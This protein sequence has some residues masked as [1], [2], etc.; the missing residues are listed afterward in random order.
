MGEGCTWGKVNIAR[1]VQRKLP[2]LE[3]HSTEITGRGIERF[4][5]LKRFVEKKITRGTVFGM[6]DQYREHFQTFLIVVVHGIL[7]SGERVSLSNSSKC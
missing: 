4:E 7:K 1:V 2:D 6:L 5:R 3:Q